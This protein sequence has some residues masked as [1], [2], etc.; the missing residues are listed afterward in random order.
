MWAARPELC[1]LPAEHQE[2]RLS[3]GR[4]GC[5][6]RVEVFF[7]GTWSTVCNSTWYELEATVLCRT[8]GCGN[9]LQ[10]PSFGHT[11]PGKMVYLCGSLQPSLAQCRWAF[12]KSAPCYQSWAAGVICN[13]TGSGS[14]PLGFEARPGSRPL[15]SIPF[16]PPPFPGSQGLET[17]TPTAEVTPGNVTV[18]HGECLSPQRPFSGIGV[19]F[20]RG[21][22]YVG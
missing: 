16:L 1:A 15:S 18:P 7:R 4:D 5:A 20:H 12:N 22:I 13:G 3:G 6:G 11:L 2:W 10:R 8:L 21:R 14:F 17:P 9:A 19:K